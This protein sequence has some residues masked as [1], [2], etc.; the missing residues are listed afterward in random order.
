VLV[1]SD[2]ALGEIN[3]LLL[4][5]FLLAQL[6]LIRK[7]AEFVVELLL[8]RAQLILSWQNYLASLP[9]QL[10]TL[11]IVHGNIIAHL[12]A[13]NLG[14]VL[15]QPIVQVQCADH[16][17]W[18]EPVVHGSLPLAMPLLAENAQPNRV[19]MV[20]FKLLVLVLSPLLVISV[21]GIT[22]SNVN[23]PNVNA[24]IQTHLPVVMLEKVLIPLEF[25]FAYLAPP[26]APTLV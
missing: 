12:I 6:L 19:P 18:P 11:K 14:V 15:N 7:E 4:L 3:A 21:L 8:P 26:F 2:S 9:P 1:L 25:Q 10:Q 20:I 16:P 23:L 17:T 24:Q 13:L 5:Q 22:A